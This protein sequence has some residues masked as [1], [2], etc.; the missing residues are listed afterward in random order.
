MHGLIGLAARIEH[1]ADGFHARLAALMTPQ[2]G[3]QVVSGP[4]VL[5]PAAFPVIHPHS[6][7]LR[8][9]ASGKVVTGLPLAAFGLSSTTSSTC[10]DR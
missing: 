3:Q 10:L 5:P 6:D 1:S 7:V 2:V 4:V 8:S 9:M